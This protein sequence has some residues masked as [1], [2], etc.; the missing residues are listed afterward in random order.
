[1]GAITQCRDR[2]ECNV[3]VTLTCAYTCMMDNSVIVLLPQLHY[4]HYTSIYVL[5]LL[6]TSHYC[7]HT[8]ICIVLLSPSPYTSISIILLPQSHC[9]QHTYINGYI[10]SCHCQHYIVV[11]IPISTYISLATWFWC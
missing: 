10:A 1:M 5:F 2:H 11:D 9:G 3:M 7:H 6:P 8:C 4:F